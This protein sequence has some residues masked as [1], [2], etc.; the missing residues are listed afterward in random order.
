VKVADEVF[1]RCARNH[2]FDPQRKDCYAVVDS[3]LDLAANL[4]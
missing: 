2:V 4:R 1:E 3:A